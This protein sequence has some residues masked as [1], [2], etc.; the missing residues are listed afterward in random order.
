M[1][2]FP[3]SLIVVT[4]LLFQTHW[5]DDLFSGQPDRAGVAVS[6]IGSVLLG[7]GYWF[8]GHV[9]G[10]TMLSAGL[11][12]VA[13]V[14]LAD[15]TGVRPDGSRTP[16]VLHHLRS[17]L[18]TSLATAVAANLVCAVVMLRRVLSRRY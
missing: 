4:I 10:R 14:S 1:R 16:A 13:L 7:G 11:V 2:L 6:A 12:F 3:H 15:L 17:E 5:I 9:V 8:R 18:G